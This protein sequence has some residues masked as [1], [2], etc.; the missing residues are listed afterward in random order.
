VSGKADESAPLT[1]RAKGKGQ[2]DDLPPLTPRQGPGGREGIV[3]SAR[4]VRVYFWRNRPGRAFLAVDGVDLDVR[5]GE[6]LAIVGPS[7]CGKTTFLNAVDGLVPVTSGSLTLSGTPITAPGHDRAMVF[8]QP[9]LLPWRNVLDNV[10]YGLDLQRLVGRRE[11]A[12]RAR[13]F[14]QLVGLKGFEDAYPLELSGGMQQR[15][16]LARALATDPDILLLDEPFAALDA[17]TREYMQLELLRIWR[18]TGKT[19]LFITHDIGEAVYLA[20]RVVVFPARPG[21]VKTTVDIGLERPRE[22]RVKRS[23]AFVAYEDRVWSA[24]EEEVSRSREQELRRA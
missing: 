1:P 19:T 4:G 11:A 12:Q 24:I 18:Q 14:V 21:R 17:Q 13:D 16:N 10:R 5:T 6:F 22:L 20:D 23:P 7:G 8:Q 15:V 3:L 9:S 2:E